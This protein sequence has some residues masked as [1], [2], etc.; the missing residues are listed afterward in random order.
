[1]F[2]NQLNLIGVEYDIRKKTTTVTSN[3]EQTEVIKCQ[4]RNMKSI[5]KKQSEKKQEEEVEQQ[6]WVGQYLT[7]QWHN[8][9]LEKESYNINKIWK[10]I[11]NVFFSIH[12]SI[13]QQF[14]TKKVCRRKKLK[15]GDGDLKCLMLIVT[16]EKKLFHTCYVNALLSHS[17][18]TKQ[19]M[20]ACYALFTPNLYRC[21]GLQ[22]MKTKCH[23]INQHLNLQERI[24]E[25]RGPLGYPNL[26]R[27]HTRKWR[28]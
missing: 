6:L 15:K 24:K 2:V 11:P 10:N 18:F 14:I 27:C 21:M 20:T 25:L 16:R 4:P 17:L 5:L 13:Q 22:K 9:D 7:N 8:K 19:D 1:M 26:P 23:V 28:K 3:K 12:T